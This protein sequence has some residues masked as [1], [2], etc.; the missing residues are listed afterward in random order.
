MEEVETEAKLNT[1]MGSL[2]CIF[3]LAL[4]RV[5]LKLQ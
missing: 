2:T 1:L 3:S 5:D 4:T